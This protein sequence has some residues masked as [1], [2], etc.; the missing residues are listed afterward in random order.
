M[1][2]AATITIADGAPTPVNH[3]FVPS[4]VS[5]LVATFYGPGTTLATREKLTV[6]RREATA[7]VAGKVNFKLELPVEQTVDG[8]VVLAYQE[9]MSADFVLAPKSTKQNRKDCRLL[10]H[11][12]LKDAVAVA[13]IDD[14]DGLF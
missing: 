14:M 9:L 12:L 6:T 4:K 5:D 13:L 2:Q 1:P 8:Q 11:N 10:A 3:S 7:T